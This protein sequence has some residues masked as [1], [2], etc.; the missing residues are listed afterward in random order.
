MY[1]RANAVHSLLAILVT[2]AWVSVE[3]R[4][5]CAIAVIF[6]EIQF[7]AASSAT[8]ITILA[9]R[10]WKCDVEIIIDASMRAAQIHIKFHEATCK[11]KGG[12][13]ACSSPTVDCPS[14]G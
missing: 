2:T 4:R 7:S 1:V 10:V 11:V 9:N 12:F 13:R 6:N 5:R 3:G 8:R 14:I